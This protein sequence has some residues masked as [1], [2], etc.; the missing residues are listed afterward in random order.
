MKK[1]V[2]LSIALT[3]LTGLGITNLI[4]NNRDD[5]KVAEAYT[6]TTDFP[7]TIDL[8]DCTETEIKNYYSALSSLSSN[9]LQGTNLL[10]NLKPILKNGQKYYSYDNSTSKKNIWRMYKITDRDWKLSPAS[11]ISGYNAST[12]TI[13]DYAYD[14]DNPYIH[15]LYINRDKTNQTLANDHTGMEWGINQEHLWAKANGFGGEENTQSTGG[16]RGDLMHLMSGNAHVNQNIHKQYY[17]AY[18]DDSRSPTN[19]GDSYSHLRGNYVGKSLTLGTNDS[20]AVFEPQ[21]SDKGDIARAMFYMVARYNFLA[22]ES[23]DDTFDNEPNL[24]LVQ[25]SVYASTS[26]TSS[27]TNPGKMGLLT[28]LLAWHHADPVDE[29]E[30]H[31]NNLLYKNYTNNRNPFIDFPEWVDYIFGKATYDGKNYQSYDSN[32]TGYVDL[33]KDI[34]NGYR[35]DET[36]EEGGEV[37]TAE[38]D[39]LNITT[40]NLTST[41]NTTINNAKSNSSASYQ[42]ISAKN[43]SS[44]FKLT[45]SSGSG[46]VQTQSGGKVNKVTINFSSSASSSVTVSLYGKNEAYTGSTD[47]D[48][49]STRGTLLGSVT[50]SSGSSID[51][52]PSEKCDYIGFKASKTVYID[53]IK[54]YFKQ[55]SSVSSINATCTKV[56]HPGDTISKSDIAVKDNNGNAVTNFAFNE[57][58]YQFLYED[59]VGG[60]ISKTK[61]FNVTYNDLTA[62]VDVVINREAYVAPMETSTTLGATEF[63]DSDV[64]KSSYTPS[65]ENVT[66]GTIPFTVTTNAYIYNKQL[67]FGKKVGSIVNT[68]PFDTPI[69]SVTITQASGGRDDAKLYVSEDGTT[70]VEASFANELTRGYRYFKIAYETTSASYSNI[71]SIVITYYGVETPQNIANYLMFED[72]INQC[73]DKYT[74]VKGL[75]NSLSKTDKNVF[76]NSEDYRIACARNRLIAWANYHHEI[77]NVNDG[78]YHLANQTTKSGHLEY[79][80][81]ILIVG[82]ISL[83]GLL[84]F[85]YRKK[86]QK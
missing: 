16:A 61:S 45:S 46:I 37:I 47:L 48:S 58:G 51:I 56:F 39:E 50:S 84:M 54:I 69:K 9:E 38:Y 33:S 53:S 19:A 49:T 23:Q 36:G 28:D 52:V 70:F 85:V 29:F 10:K 42:G 41:T 3:F 1:I 25:D 67:S 27:L 31:R 64:S 8:N 62:T 20:N 26:Y 79:V 7:S 55:A 12:N 74:I 66:I 43:S 57:D 80:Q 24:T 21:D 81:N 14:S 65:S 2:C 13:T 17:F 83:I 77:I 22:G 78:D 35:N 6:I 18:V 32:P 40:L 34:V 4:K 72:T 86:H 76:M 75:F 15:A 30:I 11:S 73:N 71:S 82:S 60:G 59:S 5:F 44:A 68:N 63:Y